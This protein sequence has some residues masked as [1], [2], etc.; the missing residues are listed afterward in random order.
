M[1]R[2]KIYLVDNGA[3][4]STSP[5]G[6]ELE[7]ACAEL[8]WIEPVT[9]AGHG[10]IGYGRANNLAIAR[11]AESDFH[12]VLNPDVK[13][14]ED[15]IANAFRYLQAHADCSLV[16]PVATAPDGAPLYLVKRFPDLF[17]LLLRGFAPMS[18]RNRFRARLAAYERRETPFDASLSD[19]EIASGCF[20]LI[21]RSA[22]TR[23]EGFDPAF[24]LYFEDFDLSYRI[25]KFAGIA[26]VADVRILHAGGNAAAKGFAHMWWFVRSALRFHWKHRRRGVGRNTI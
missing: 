23:A 8:G 1:R 4:D 21:R 7:S 11:S 13:L 20:M 22:L 19:V 5:F 17:T 26:R 12:L 6:A 15:A 9:I 24:F 10:N 18:I 2:A 14:D 3:A 25:A 16:S